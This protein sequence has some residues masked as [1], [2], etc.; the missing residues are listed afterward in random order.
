MKSL[1][2]PHL[3]L[4]NLTLFIDLHN[5]LIN[6]FERKAAFLNKNTRKVVIM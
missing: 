6:V 5:I 3:R 2:L 1:H 4:S